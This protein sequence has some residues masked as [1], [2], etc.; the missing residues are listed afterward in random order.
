MAETAA[1]DL[2]RG[3]VD[4]EAAKA[5]RLKS[6]RT[7]KRTQ[8]TGAVEFAGLAQNLACECRTKFG[9]VYQCPCTV[10]GR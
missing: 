10:S 1:G 5:K 7:N 4:A 6:L 9:E 3:T 8:R 2:I